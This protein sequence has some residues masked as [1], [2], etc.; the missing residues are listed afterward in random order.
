MDDQTPNLSLHFI[1]PSQAQKH[2]THNEAIRQLDALVQMVAESRTLTEP[3]AD[4][5]IGA[6][7]L[8]PAEASGAWE[9]QDNF[10]AV[11]QDGAFVYLSPK[12]GWRT[13][14]KGEGIFLFDGAE[15]VPLSSNGPAVDLDNVDQFGINT[16]ADDH[17]RLTVRSNAVLLTHETGDMRAIVNK[18][19]PENTASFL[20]QTNFSGRA[21][22]GLTGNDDFHFRVSSD[23]VQFQDS[24]ILDKQTGQANFPNGFARNGVSSK[25]L[26]ASYAQVAT[27]SGPAAVRFQDSTSRFAWEGRFIIIG[28]G[29]GA[30]FSESGFFDIRQPPEGTEILNSE[31]NIND[32]ITSDGVQILRWE[33]LYYVLPI[34]EMRDSKPTHFRL[35][36]Y[37]DEFAFPSEEVWVFV[38]MHNGDTGEIRLGNGEII[39][40]TDDFIVRT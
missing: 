8:I 24:L 21:E 11:F 27:L 36:D 17:N 3:P 2:V 7:Y 1:M 37:R 18:Q 6:I 23:G 32:T 20:F 31:G 4:P 28:A 16:S 39:H 38:A 15:W 29:H 12:E 33:V 5:A 26:T 40:P 13:Y 34:G 10:I 19:E 25:T 35:I 14:V 30:H 22:I 9:N